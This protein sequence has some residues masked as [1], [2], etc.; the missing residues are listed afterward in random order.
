MIR[1]RRNRA[2]L[3]GMGV[4]AA[5]GT[6]IETFWANLVEG[7]SGIGPITLFDASDLPSRIAGEVKQFDPEAY[8]DPK[9]KPKRMGRFTQLGVA[10]AR[11]AF[12]DAG[13]TPAE[14]RRPADLP[15]VM[16]VSTNAMDL[17]E[18]E[19]QIHT[20]VTG[21]PVALSSAVSYM[22]DIHARL[23]TVSN[24]CASGLDA[25]AAAA[26]MI[27]RGEVDLALA[28]G[29]E[30]GI[31]RYVV[32]CMLKCRKCS[33]RNDT[34]EKAS[35]P[36]DR[37]RDY[38]VLAEGAGVVTLENF[39]HARARGAR[40]YAEIVNQGSCTDNAD[41]PEGGGFSTSMTRALHN[42]GLYTGDIDFISAH[43]PSDI[44]MDIVETDCIKHVFADRAYGIPVTSIKGA[45]GCPMGVGGVLQLMAASLSVRHGLIPPTTNYETPDPRCDL[46]YVP[47]SPRHVSVRHGVINTHGFGRGNT[48]MVVRKAD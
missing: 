10:A 2:V 37:W 44:Y 35:R 48:S 9:L 1:T 13:L 34:P 6:G 24:G 32:N 33:M 39:D 36:F 31:V 30:S 23:L 5:N 4:L 42:S 47:G 22:H 19:P 17:N 7:R 16:G 28:G 25:V 46:D 21:I 27:R 8:V 41:D 26:A 11:L 18:I 43:G 29:A 45:T 15:V 3:T 12:Q 38:G 14:L 20:A 40:I